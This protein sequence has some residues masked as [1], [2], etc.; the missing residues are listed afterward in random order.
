M[1]KFIRIVALTLTPALV[2]SCAAKGSGRAVAPTTAPAAAHNRQVAPGVAAGRAAAS[3]IAAA[4]TTARNAAPT[5]HAP[6]TAAS[7]ATAPAIAP[8]TATNAAA[9]G[10]TAPAIAEPGQERYRLVNQADEIVSVLNNGATVIVKRFASPVLSVRGYVKTG[11]VYEG[12]WL[13]GGLSHLLEHLVAGGSNQRR[14]E[15]ENREMLQHIGNNSNAYTSQSHTA[16]FVN[17]TPQHLNQAADLI[18]GW[19]LTALIT[20]EEYAR[21]YQVVQRELEMGKGEPGRQF[22]YLSNLNRYRLSPARVPVIGYQSV[23]QGLSRD[24]V[25]SYYRQA[26]QPNN[27]VFVIVGDLPPQTMLQAMQKQLDSAAAG[28]EFSH[29]IAE[30]PPVLAPRTLASAMPK[31]G[32]AKL[33]LAFPTIKLSDPDL[34]A[35]DLLATALADGESALLVRELRDKRQLVSAISASS[36]T[37]EFVQ[38]SFEIDM[39]LPPDKIKPATEALLELLRQVKQKPLDEQSIQ[40]AKTQMRAGRI[41]GMQTAEAVAS[42]LAGD[43]LSTGDIHFTDHYLQRIGEVTAEQMRQAAGR[44][45]DEGKLLTTVMLPSEVAPTLP[46]AEQ[47]IRAAAAAATRPAATAPS[48]AVVRRHVLDNGTILLIKRITTSPLVQIQMY[49]LGG[50]SAET[51]S[52]NGLG[53]LAMELLPRGAGENDAEKIAT[54][55]D[56]K[57]ADFNSGCGNNTWF[58]NANCLKE[59]FAAVMG[60]YGQLVN[61]PTFAEPELAAMK[62]RILTAIDGQDASWQSQ[63]MRFFKQAYF[64]PLNSPYQFTILGERKTVEQLTAQQVRDYYSQR[65]S[66]SRRVL[67]IYGDVDEAEA[68]KLAQQSVGQGPKLIE[69]PTPAPS[70]AA[71]AQP[72]TRPTLQVRAVKVQTTQQP[73]AGVVIGFD[74][75]SVIGTPINDPLT[76]GTTMASGFGYPTGYLHETLRGQGLV[77]MVF[78]QNWPGRDAQHPGAYIAYA[79]CDPTKVNQVVELILLNLARLQGSDADMQRSW[80]E[81]SKQLILTEDAMS[82]ETPAQQATT[83]ALDELYGLGYDRDQSFARRISDVNLTD[84]RSAFARR[85][86][87]CVITISTPLPQQVNIQPGMRNYDS[88]PPVE[89]T[90]RGVQHDVQH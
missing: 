65:I 69:T 37:P 45:F 29:D 64:G 75:H 80:F 41:K 36:G 1:L 43:Y 55:F 10:A 86:R 20:P 62:Q 84:V 54:F 77:Y 9:S 34:Y 22:Y 90:P 42:S 33:E 2:V 71:S 23:I 28:R 18:A 60:M 39:Q 35:L 14:G 31:L 78:A 74:S 66:K 46:Q 11:G 88:F 8:T 5:A 19:M 57:G 49:A 52:T 4:P 7:A 47:L 61:Q 25:Y 51:Q 81:R 3:A 59:D 13:G 70:D 56:A 68:L 16:Y 27:M 38:G 15:A 40:T 83:A 53:N 48:A 72:A 79:G 89:L 73:L 85:V 87:S 17:T 76:V 6:A 26:Y 21:E 82:K 67:A 63:S 44:Y 50:L 24:D 30:E 32:A 58:W 12:K